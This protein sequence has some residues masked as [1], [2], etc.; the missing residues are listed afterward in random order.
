MSSR[1]QGNPP[2]N[3][4]V[5]NVDGGEEAAQESAT[6]R[7]SRLGAL[8]MKAKGAQAKESS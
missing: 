3:G 4:V 5:Y 7:R 2:Q 8:K 1:L 6:E